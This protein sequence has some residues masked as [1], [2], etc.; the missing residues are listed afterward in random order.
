[1]A[2]QSTDIDAALDQMASVLRSLRSAGQ[3]VKR[4]TNRAVSE[5]SQFAQ[6]YGE[7]ISAVSA[8][9]ASDD[10]VDKLQSAKLAKIVGEA[11]D[12]HAK[13]QAVKVGIDRLGL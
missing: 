3:E 1:M 5:L 10:P 6:T 2:L 11:Q 9:Q 13:V 7:V 4:T 8:L 12:L